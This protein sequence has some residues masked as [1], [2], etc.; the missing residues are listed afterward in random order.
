MKTLTKIQQLPEYKGIKIHSFIIMPSKFFG[1][2]CNLLYKIIGFDPEND[3]VFMN[4]RNKKTMLIQNKSSI[5]EGFK[6]NTIIK[7][8]NKVK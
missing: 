7:L 1:K 5:A 2:N 4:K 8:L 6:Y 3:I